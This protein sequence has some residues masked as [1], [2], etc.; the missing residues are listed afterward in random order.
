MKARGVKRLSALLF[1]HPL[2]KAKMGQP[3]VKEKAGR[4]VAKEVFH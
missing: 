4:D 2:Q 3:P 1:T